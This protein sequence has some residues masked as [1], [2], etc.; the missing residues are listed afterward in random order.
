MLTKCEYVTLVQEENS[1]RENLFGFHRSCGGRGGRIN[2]L[3]S[4]RKMI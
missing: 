2:S 1:Q 3:T 4:G